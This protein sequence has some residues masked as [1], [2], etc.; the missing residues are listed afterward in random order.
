MGTR[1]ASFLLPHVNHVTLYGFLLL[2][3]LLL[4]GFDV[5]L[6]ALLCDPC[7][8]LSQVVVG[9]IDCVMAT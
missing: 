7:T 9:P 6:S 1:A 2:C 8:A 4:W 5:S 3:S